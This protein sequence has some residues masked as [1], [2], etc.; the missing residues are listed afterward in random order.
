MIT[1]NAGQAAALAAI[2]EF[3]EG[4]ESFFVLSGSAGTG[5]TSLLNFVPDLVPYGEIVGC[6]PTHK[7]V[8]VLASKLP[9]SIPTCTIHKFLGLR[10]KRTGEKTVLTLRKDFD[11]SA[12]VE[13][14]V[15]LLDEGSMAGTDLLNHILRDAEYWERK[16]IIIG[17]A[18]Q[19]NPPGEMDTPCFHMKAPGYE[20]REIVRQAEDSPII[21]CATAIRDALIDDQEPPV[22]T[23]EHGD[24]GVYRMSKKNW[25]GELAKHVTDEN[26]DR[27]RILAYRNDT[28][29][30]YNQMVRELLGK[31][32]SVPFSPGE[33]V[34]VNEAYTQDESV[35]MNT[36]EEYLVEELEPHQHPAYES[37]TGWLVRIGNTK[38]PV[39][40]HAKCGDAYKALIAKMVQSAKQNNDWRAYYRM[41][42]YWCDLRPMYAMTV[43]KSQ[44]ST[45]DNV[46]IDYA[47]IYANRILAEADRC[48]Y[49]AV[50][51]PRYNAFILG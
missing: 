38:V 45:F 50:T 40:D 22:I 5:K 12:N 49:V 33:Y 18:Y 37:L 31:D 20:L 8:E 19:L 36:G 1:P 7:S 24:L 34:M 28:V 15:V 17:D 43:H 11:M 2:K 9:K 30:R 10:P 41:S 4:K 32:M 14:R 51:R 44:G 25:M 42:E 26:P 39:L 13:V 3:L 46:F 21:K 29:R 23:G 48:L 27:Y 35:I 6:G 47:D 16:Y